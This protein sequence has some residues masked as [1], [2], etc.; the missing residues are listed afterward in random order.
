MNLLIVCSRFKDL[1]F[2]DKIDLSKYSKVI[3]ASDNL[4]IHKNFHQLKMIKKL[5]F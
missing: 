2:I 1:S 4:R 5:H 3:L